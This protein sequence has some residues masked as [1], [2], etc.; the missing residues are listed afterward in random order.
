MWKAIKIYIGIIIFFGVWR[1]IAEGLL[2]YGLDHFWATALPITIFL[3]VLAFLGWIIELMERANAK[4][5]KPQSN[6]AVFIHRRT[7]IY[8]R[9]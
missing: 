6:H 1:A 4:D 8:R 3:A 2:R 9:Q 7:R 5:Q